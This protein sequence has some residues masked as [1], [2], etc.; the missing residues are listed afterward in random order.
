[1]GHLFHLSF[2]TMFNS[3]LFPGSRISGLPFISFH[4]SN[5]VFLRISSQCA[6]LCHSLFVFCSAVCASTAS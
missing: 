1:M 3:D 6:T 4:W 2:A 5:R